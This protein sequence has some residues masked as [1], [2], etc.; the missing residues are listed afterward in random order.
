MTCAAIKDGIVVNVVVW[1]GVTEYNPGKG[2]ELVCIDETNV[3][4]G[5]SYADGK[6]TAPIE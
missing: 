2:I 5:W 6:F 1:D 4:I 3:G